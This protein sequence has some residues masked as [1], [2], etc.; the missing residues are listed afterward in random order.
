MANVR[1]ERRLAAILIA[2]IVGYSRMLEADEARTL[3][4]IK[5]LHD[6][7]L[8]PLFAE[9][10]GR[11]VKLTG[12]GV[13]VEFSS[14]VDAVACAVA[15]QHQIAFWQKEHP[16][17]SRIVFRIGV[18]LGDVVVDRDDLFGDGI[19]IAARLEALSE[20]GGLCISDAVHTQLSGKTTIAFQDAGEQQLKNITRPVRVWRWTDAPVARVMSEPLALPERPSIAVLPFDNLSGQAEESYFCDGITE[21]IITGLARFRSIFVI[22]RNSSFSFRGK[23]VDIAE[24]A[25]K[26]GVSYV[27]EGSIRRAAGRVRIAAQL[28]EAATGAHLWAERYDRSLDDIFAVQDDVAQMIVSTLVG[29]IE[30]SRLQHSLRKPTVSLT[31]YECVLRGIAHYRGYAEDD[32]QKAFEMFE[33]AVALDPRYA[34]AHAYLARLQLA[35]HGYAAAPTEILDEAFKRATHALE[36]DP[37]EGRCHVALGAVWLYRREFE[38]AEHHHRQAFQLNPNN[39]DRIMGLGYVIALRGRSKEALDWMARAIRLNPFH[40]TWYYTQQAIPLYSLGRYAEAAT[41][42]KRVPDPGYW[43]SARLAACHALLGQVAEAK[44]ASANVLRMRPDFST[45]DFLMRDVLLERPEDRDHLREG[46]IKAGLP[47]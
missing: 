22:A 29:R 16:P 12:D 14:A 37:R 2:D 23:H 17:E 28:I 34:V 13:I 43:S 1:V 35:L 10:R 11:I 42:L 18:S 26:L 33:R 27:V 5:R 47:E 40:H 39:A 6:E 31:A 20:P 44:I 32:N 15:L 38:T 25:G 46:L 8:D 9:H 41:N 19:N 4:S 7:V 45:A 30:E 24:I 36:L 3:A 21:E